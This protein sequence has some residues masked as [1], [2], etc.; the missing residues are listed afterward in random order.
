MIEFKRYKKSIKDEDKKYGDNDYLTV[1]KCLK[2]HEGKD[3]HWLVYGE[4]AN[5]KLQLKYRSYLQEE[6]DSSDKVLIT[7]EDLTYLK[8]SV[9]T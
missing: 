2:E 9:F 4:A 6:T 7:S 8:L 3:L 5:N 1:C